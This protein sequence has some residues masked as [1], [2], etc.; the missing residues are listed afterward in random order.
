MN[1]VS[2]ILAIQDLSCAGVPHVAHNNYAVSI[3]PF[4]YPW[5]IYFFNFTGESIINATNNPSPLPNEERSKPIQH[6]RTMIH[7]IWDARKQFSIS[8]TERVVPEGNSII[9]AWMVVP[10]HSR[11]KIIPAL[12]SRYPTPRFFRIR[13]L[14]PK[15]IHIAP[16]AFFSHLFIFLFFARSP[17]LIPLLP[18][19]QCS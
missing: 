2:G 17:H 6:L 9:P 18:H 16:Q 3:K 15:L 5:N 1:G 11:K 10:R 14:N 19:T 7:A 12:L 8:F 13:Q 4:S